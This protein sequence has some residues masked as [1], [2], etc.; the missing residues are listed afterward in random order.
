MLSI[1]IPTF[2]ESRNLEELVKRIFASLNSA[3]IDGEVVVVDDNSPDGTAEIAEKLKASYRI[4]VLKRMGRK[5]LS[6]AVI[7][8]FSAAGGDILCVMDADLSHPP[9]KIPEMYKTIIDGE[10]DLVIGSRLVPGGGST[11]WSLGR[12]LVSFIARVIAMPIT[13]V[14]DL[15]SGFFMVKRS[16]IEGANLSPMGFKIGLEILAKGNY[17]KAKE[18]PIIFA[19]RKKGKSKLSAKQVLEYLIQLASLYCVVVIKKIKGKR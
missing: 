15:T 9:E 1:I 4:T 12:K 16:V 10:A 13:S 2:N 11:D 17:N 6:S 3:G 8:G 18:V 14:K 5:G 7:D 19:G